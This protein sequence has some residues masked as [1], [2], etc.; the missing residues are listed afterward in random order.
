MS[1][2]NDLR[3]EQSKALEA[4]DR[5]N[6]C[7]SEI[8]AII[9]SADVVPIIIYREPLLIG[10]YQSTIDLF[11]N[12]FNLDRYQIGPNVVMDYVD[13]T[14]GKYRSDHSKAIFRMFN[15]FFYLGLLLAPISDMLFEGIGK[16]GFN[17]Q[18]TGIIDLRKR[19]KGCAVSTNY[20]GSTTDYFAL[21]RPP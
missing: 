7:L 8:H 18:K 2:F 6:L 10:G 21:F 20:S 11:E 17:R 15:L 4:R 13:R 5:I 9:L 16:L 14:I 3:I 1:S 19:G 12:I